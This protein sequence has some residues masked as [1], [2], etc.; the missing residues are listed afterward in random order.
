MS[1]IRVFAQPSQGAFLEIDW[2]LRSGARV[3]VTVPAFDIGAGKLMVHELEQ[4][5]E[6]QCSAESSAK[7]N[8]FWYSGDA[9]LFQRTQ[10]QSRLLKSVRVIP[11]DIYDFAQEIQML[12]QLPLDSCVGIVSLSSG[13]VRGQK[14]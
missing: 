4:P 11:V 3:L 13:L 5:W 9:S 8:A 7:S 12:K 14:R 6:Y 1:S 10:R 2:R